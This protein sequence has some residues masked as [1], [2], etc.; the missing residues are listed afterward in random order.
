MAIIHTPRSLAAIA[1]GMMKRRRRL[2]A[3]TGTG[4]TND[5]NA[6]TEDASGF[7]GFLPSRGSSKID[8]DN[9]HVYK[10]RPNILWDVD[11]LGHMNNASYLTHSEYARWEWT[12]ET[13]ALRSMYDNGM[14]FVVT[15][16]A[17]RFRKEIRLRDS[18]Q[19]RSHL[20]AI[21]DRHLWMHQTFR[22]DGGEG[23]ILA[24]VLVQAVTVKDRGI[25]PP[26]TVL[27]AI[28]IPDGVVD[29][30]VWR[31]GD[32]SSGGTAQGDE[33]LKFLERFRDL[34]VAFRREA[35]ADDERLRDVASRRN[36]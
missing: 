30:L 8:D 25:V 21:D 22:S 12:T 13:G 7:V 33:A 16:S 9:A 34:D 5:K 32:D 3:I 28:G 15:Q 14:N 36:E 20:H 19:I 17:I 29:S 23:R 6:A 4:S 11:Y 24:Q 27:E 2:A 18:F 1:R 26:R 35:T 31:D 10:S